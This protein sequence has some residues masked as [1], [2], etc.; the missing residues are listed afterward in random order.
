MGM[1]AGISLAAMAS[2]LG[3]AFASAAPALAYP[4][5]GTLMGTVHFSTPCGSLGV[6]VA[7]DN[8]YL[9]YTCYSN[10]TDLLRA[11]PTTGA[12]SATYG[13]DGGLGA[14]AYDSTRN[15]IWA[16]PGGPNPDKIWLIQLDALHNVA[17]SAI[18]FSTRPGDASSLDDG[19][20]FD[21]TDDTLYF[22]P[23]AAN[24]IHHYQTNGTFINDITGAS[25][26][27]GN[28][29]SGLAIGGNLLFEGK[30]GCSH[31]YVVDKNTLAPAFDFSTAVAGDPNF[32][33]EGLTCDN[34]TF[35]PVDVMWSKEAY[36]PMRA[37]AFA[38]PAGTCGVGG[39]PPPVIPEAHQPALLIATGG[40]V[41]AG[42]GLLAARR[43][44]SGLRV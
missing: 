1:R 33:D 6:G 19:I 44:R 15:A 9:W 17:S 4:A 21:S 14:I 36:E 35:A 7:F 26:C 3:L 5:N 25:S 8:Q 34:K 42:F 18:A 24:P 2:L 23:D 41:M 29:T 28:G 39:L 20:A 31:V 27:I 13:I 43:R 37:A 40:L 32:R 10:P 11:D 38:I 22:K 16:A 12:V 30:D